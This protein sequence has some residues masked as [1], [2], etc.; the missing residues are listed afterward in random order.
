MTLDINQ[1]LSATGLDKEVKGEDI[2]DEQEKEVVESED[3]DEVVDDTKDV[4]ST[5]TDDDDSSDEG[6]PDEQDDEDVLEYTLSGELKKVNLKNQDDRARVKTALE[7]EG[8]E[9]TTQRSVEA[10]KRAETERDAFA[11]KLRELEAMRDAEKPLEPYRRLIEDPVVRQR[12]GVQYKLP[13][14]QYNAE[15][16][17]LAAQN[18][19]LQQRQFNTDNAQELVDLQ[20]TLKSDLGLDE[21]Q[22]QECV[23]YLQ[24]EGIGYDASRPVRDQRDHIAKIVNVARQALIGQGRLPNP[25]VIKAQAEAEAIKKRLE[26]SKKRRGKRSPTAGAG[27]LNSATGKEK[28]TLAG[29]TADDLLK[30]FKVLSGK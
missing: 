14:V 6:E 16:A 1:M 25:E 10:R 3:A 23:G 21:K 15:A 29:A 19:I 7:K 4:E 12:L 17:R 24:S 26:A 18:A 27:A 13:H 22:L 11:I 2:A 20:E 9:I 5:D 30:R 28:P 8:L